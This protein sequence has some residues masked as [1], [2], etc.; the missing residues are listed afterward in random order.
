MS[1]ARQAG[2]TAIALTIAGSDSSGGAGI[3]ADLK[4]F[5]AFGVYGASAITALTAQNTRGVAAV[6][7]VTPAFV[8]AQIEAVLSDLKVGAIKTGMLANAGIVEA[9]ARTLREAPPCPLVVDP[10]MVAT[11][12]DI[13]LAPDAVDAVRRELVPL[14]TVITPNL[15][16]AACLLGTKQAQS[17]AEAVAQARALLALGCKAVL[18]K[19]GHG[20]GEGAVDILC[21]GAGMERFARPRIDTPHTHGTG[22]ALSA[23]IAALTAQGAGLREA[24]ARAK[25]FVWEGLT[26]GRA[27][28]VGRGRGPIDHLFAI[29][30]GPPPA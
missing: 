11:S 24:I 13:L 29:R 2:K 28:E 7:P 15:A 22:C 21:D 30:R 26:H 14:A 8:V 9:V 27:L 6:E 5:S 25:T 3:Q 16:E 4:T 12:G 19:G 23:A 20:S 1:A 10:V 17:E 18:V